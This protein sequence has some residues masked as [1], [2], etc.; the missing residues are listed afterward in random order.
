MRGPA[1]IVHTHTQIT[2]NLNIVE[3]KNYPTQYF[4]IRSPIKSR[5]ENF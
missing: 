2:P 3:R 5:Y 1:I 4:I